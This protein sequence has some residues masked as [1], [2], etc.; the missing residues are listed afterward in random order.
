MLLEKWIS[1]EIATLLNVGEHKDRV[2]G[3]DRCYSDRVDGVDK[4]TVDGVDR[5]KGDANSLYLDLYS[6]PK[7]QYMSWVLL[8]C[9]P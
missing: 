8:I 1:V 2:N 3:V 5:D 7:P 6:N 4:D 9:N